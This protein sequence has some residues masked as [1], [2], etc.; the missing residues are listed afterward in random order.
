MRLLLKSFVTEAEN[1]VMNIFTSVLSWRKR[2]LNFPMLVF[3]LNLEIK[4][5]FLLNIYMTLTKKK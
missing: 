4:E 5:V 1:S 3:I 2:L